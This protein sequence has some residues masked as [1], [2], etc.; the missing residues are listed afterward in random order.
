MIVLFAPSIIS[1]VLVFV[2]SMVAELW[3]KTNL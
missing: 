1:F 3:P 2:L